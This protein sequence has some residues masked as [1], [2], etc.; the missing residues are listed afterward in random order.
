MPE[1]SV[2]RTANRDREL[3]VQIASG[4][5]DALQTLYDRFAVTLYAVAYRILGEGAD[6]DEVVLDVFTQVWQQASQF[7]PERGSVAAWL[8][9]IARSRAIDLVRAKRR[10]DRVKEAAALENPGASPAMGTVRGEPDVGAE[11]SERRRYV[12]KALE[13]LPAEQ[14]VAIELAYFEGL[15]QSEIAARLGEP[16]GTVKTRIRAAMQK[17]RDTLRPIYADRLI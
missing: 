15:S 11:Q 17:L 4:E 10:R 1:A 3:V 12:K 2:P 9:M 5:Q 14:R 8:T 7:D 16:L 13:D 6:A